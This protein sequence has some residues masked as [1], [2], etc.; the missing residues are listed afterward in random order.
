MANTPAAVGTIKIVPDMS[1][2]AARLTQEISLDDP[3]AR[4][5]ID[6]THANPE[7]FRA[8]AVIG[9]RTFQLHHWTVVARTNDEPQRLQTSWTEHEIT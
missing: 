8:Y 9:D 1:E 3:L 7:G 6:E 2:F 4:A 5:I